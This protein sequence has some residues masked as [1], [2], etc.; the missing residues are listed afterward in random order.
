MIT[1]IISKILATIMLL[2]IPISIVGMFFK[3]ELF[4]AVLASDLMLIALL[5]VFTNTVKTSKLQKLGW[6]LMA[7]FYV[8]ALIAHCVF[9]DFFANLFTIFCLIFECIGYSLVM[10]GK[11]VDE[12]DK[13]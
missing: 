12:D 5:L 6:C 7:T 13:D 11:G 9:T 3:F 2:L 4:L 8:G 1:N 10:L